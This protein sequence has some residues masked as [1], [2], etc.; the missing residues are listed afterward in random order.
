MSRYDKNNDHRITAKVMNPDKENPK[1]LG[2]DNAS[3]HRIALQGYETLA[4]A[5]SDSD[6]QPKERDVTYNEGETYPLP[7][8]F[9][10]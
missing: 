2:N 4:R 3:P 7:Y 8:Y 1:D 6:Y 10:L 9:N 5:H